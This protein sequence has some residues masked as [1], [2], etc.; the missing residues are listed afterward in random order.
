MIKKTTVGATDADRSKNYRVPIA[1]ITPALN[2][3]FSRFVSRILNCRRGH[4]DRDGSWKTF[5]YFAP[6]YLHV[7]KNKL[8]N[9]VYNAMSKII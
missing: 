6:E 7:D 5:Y 1:P 3:C 4:M 8:C 2:N 9:R